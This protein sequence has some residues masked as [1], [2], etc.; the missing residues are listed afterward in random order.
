MRQGSSWPPKVVSALNLPRRV[1]AEF[2]YN[3]KQG[4]SR[5]VVVSSNGDGS[6]TARKLSHRNANSS[7]ETR[8]RSAKRVSEKRRKLTPTER[9][10]RALEANKARIEAASNWGTASE[11]TLSQRGYD[12]DPY[13]GGPKA[14]T[15]K[16][17]S[18]KGR[19]R[20]GP[21]RSSR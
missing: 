12:I 1:G 18:A 21:K 20:R 5:W 7:N 4:K 2:T 17:T 16:A 13:G 6:I 3:G 15:Q 8:P 19:K 14:P 9:A 11:G 10:A